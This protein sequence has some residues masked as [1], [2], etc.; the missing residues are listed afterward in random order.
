MTGAGDVVAFTASLRFP[1]LNLRPNVVGDDP[2]F[3]RLC[4]HPL[5]LGLGRLNST[6]SVRVLNEALTIPNDESDI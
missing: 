4:G 6:A 1:D 3:W 5:Y 2:Q